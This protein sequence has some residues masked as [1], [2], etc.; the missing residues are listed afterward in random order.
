MLDLT[1]ATFICRLV[2]GA[3]LDGQA[4]YLLDGREVGPEYAPADVRGFTSVTLDL[5]LQPV[6]TELRR[7]RGRGFAAIL[8]GDIIEEYGSS[9][10]RIACA[11]AVHEAA[12]FVQHRGCKLV[13][14][15][16]QEL[17][18]WAES[19]AQPRASVEAL[20]RVDAKAT[21]EVPWAQHG[22]RFV[23]ALSHLTLRAERYG[24]CFDPEEVGLA[25]EQYG[26]SD[27]G[28]YLRAFADEAR[29]RVDQPVSLIIDSE[30]PH[31]AAELFRDDQI[32]FYA[33]PAGA[34]VLT[35]RDEAK[36]RKAKRKELASVS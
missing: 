9:A 7:W 19:L 23:R 30:P 25:G 24:H 22:L 3:D 1:T 17:P 5:E 20:A 8:C 13:S 32:K 33:S 10:E 21:P 12:H 6:L 31:E 15:P 28:L 4:V 29:E 11:V 35:A 2:C 18:A 34:V 14:L 16:R 27:G 36:E 26:L